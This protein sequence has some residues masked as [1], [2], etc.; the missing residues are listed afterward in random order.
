MGSDFEFV[1]EDSMMK[2]MTQRV[3][4]TLNVFINAVVLRWTVS[5]RQET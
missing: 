1:V 2:S 3:I 5:Q 4:A